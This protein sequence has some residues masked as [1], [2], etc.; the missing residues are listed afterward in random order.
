[1]TDNESYGKC[2]CGKGTDETPAGTRCRIVAMDALTAFRQFA[3]TAMPM[4]YGFEGWHQRL[5]F[6]I[7]GIVRS[8]FGFSYSPSCPQR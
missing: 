7:R 6:G 5:C 8:A 3:V 1:M 4:N 2:G